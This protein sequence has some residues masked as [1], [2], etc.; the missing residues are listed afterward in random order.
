LKQLFIGWNS[1]LKSE[2]AAAALP[3]VVETKESGPSNAVAKAHGA[4]HMFGVISFSQS[5]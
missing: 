1:F 4:N 2:P 3:Q 5:P